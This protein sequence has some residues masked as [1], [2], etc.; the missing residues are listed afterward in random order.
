MK[1]IIPII[2]SLLFAATAS[3]STRI[4]ETRTLGLLNPLGI[5]STPTFS[6]K[7]KSDKRGYIQKAYEITVTDALGNQVWNSGRV[8]SSRQTDIPYSGP[9]LKSRTKYVWTVTSYDASGSASEKGEGA[10]ETALLS[11]NE[12]AS[13]A[14]IAPKKPQ[15]RARVEIQPKDKNRTTRYVK[16]DVQSSGPHAA[17]DPNYGFVQIAEME[18]YDK[19]GNNVARKAKFTAANAWELSGYG[20]SVDYINDGI[21]SGGAT[22]GFTTT[23][24]VTKTAI[25]ADL[26][27]DV[28]VS[29]IVLYPRQDAP[30]VNDPE[31]AANFPS[32]YTVSF[33][34][35]SEYYSVQYEAKNAAAPSYASDTN[36]PYI[37]C[38]FLVEEGKSVASARLYAS[39]LG[40][41]NMRMNGQL[42][43]DNVLEPGES[44]YD[45]HVLYSTYDVTRLIH[46]GRNALIS[47]V[48]GG[49]ANM[50][51]MSDRFV[52]PEL[53][54]NT[55]T[56][57]LRAL[58]YITYTDGTEQCI[59]TDGTWVTRESPTTGSNWYG[60][61]DYDARRQLDGVFGVGYELN[62]WEQCQTVSP[63]FCAPSV[64]ATVH[65]VGQMRAR[66]YEPL[67]VVESWP[68]VSVT[69]NAAGNY[70]VDFGQNFAG[71]YSFH[72]AAP[73]GTKITLYD[74]EL[75]ENGACKFEYMYEPKGATN[76]TLD[77]Y[78]FRGDKDG[79]TWGPE[80]MYHGFRYLEISGLTE[81]PD[82]QAFTAKRIR[83]A[84]DV[85]GSFHT[86]NALLNDIHKMCFRGIESQLYN[87]VTD[88]PH[89]EKLGWLD[90]P[91]MMYQSLSYNFD[92]KNL[93][94]KVVMDAFDSQGANNYVPSTVP[95]FMRAYDDDLNWGGAAITIPWR[96]YKMYG[97]KTLMTRYYAQMKALMGYYGS[98]TDN[99][100]IRNYSVLSDWGQQTSGL[101]QM[102]SSPFTLT[103][104]Y[105]YLLQAMAEVATELGHEADATAWT[106]EAAEVKKAF[107]ARF[108]NEGVYEFGNQAN[109]GMALYYGL[110]DDADVP[111]VAEALAQA[112]RN[113]GY[114][115]K[116]GE[117]GLRPTLMSLARNG[118]ND[119]V[120]KMA[121]KTTYPSYGYWLKQG[122][123]TSLEYWDMSLSQ[124]HCMMDHIEEWF[125]GQLGGIVNAGEAYETVDI[126]P[127][128][129]ADLATADVS[130]ESPRGTIR[131]A[132]NR[133][134]SSTTYE[135]SIPAGTEAHVVLPVVEGKTLKEGKKD[136]EKLAAVSDVAYADTLVRFVLHSGD[137]VFTM[138]ASTLTEDA[139]DDDD[140]PEGEDVTDTY[141]LNPGFELK[142]TATIPWSPTHWN[143]TFPGT[144]GDYGKLSTSDQRSV[145]PKEGKYDWH[146]WYNAD[147][148]SVRLAQTLHLPMGRYALYGDMRCVDNAA[149]T[150]AQRL[151]AT[152]GTM[153][154][155]IFS[156]PYNHDQ[157]INISSRDNENLMNWQTL[158]LVLD[159]PS[160]HDVTIG[161]DCPQSGAGTLM[162]GFQVDHVRLF[163]LDAATS[164]SATGRT[165]AVADGCYSLSGLPLKGFSRN[166]IVVRTEEGRAVKVM[167]Q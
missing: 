57:S 108:F 29:R 28:E 27:Q 1:R 118:Y 79:E 89:R 156:D 32:T 54:S 36:I 46:K 88:C 43:T 50:S 80:F 161:F 98:L 148:V 116:T 142:N 162:G 13:A 38:N 63:T 166:Q 133:T 55:A 16:L 146:I 7:I 107:N 106:D 139:G 157:S 144:D 86:S 9:A 141:I 41:F 93:L 84:M 135:L 6:W 128:I 158:S 48:A 72:L 95:H 85:A 77:T 67:R 136:I 134:A 81:A 25:V 53:A 23:Q 164:I 56:T 74:S 124:N 165:R 11:Q 113:S 152:T 129:P 140:E 58:L 75:Q 70:L 90:V 52:K 40:V 153:E 160:A 37:G 73:A 5:E 61:E 149:I 15:Y 10:F 66:E 131:M 91:N 125:F 17:S 44:A 19:D 64:A 145:N 26:G 159:L 127:W 49:I 163:R 122:A 82:P 21:I 62:G 87:T 104:T 123:T 100:I 99:H 115:I 121:K 120:Y 3:A 150:G 94:S 18:I 167:M 110:V 117:I 59:P 8:A 143:L 14:W 114:C 126:Q 119:V 60:G 112:V 155:A 154:E 65:S 69:K 24:N 83:S 4:V 33:S 147:Y 102:T 132:W 109:Y 137:Y 103:C 12:W 111:A 130:V 42:V 47:Q 105:Y 138:D 2:S 151:F 101:S 78:T 20:W 68:A 39:A 34:D 31:H 97:D 76:K 35:N 51:K 45:K 22:N 71:T 96:N 92:V 30:A